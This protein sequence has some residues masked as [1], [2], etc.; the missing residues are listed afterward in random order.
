MFVRGLLLLNIQRT[1]SRTENRK[2]FNIAARTKVHPTDVQRRVLRALLSEIE[3]QPQD[4]QSIRRLVLATSSDQDRLSALLPRTE[5]QGRGPNRFQPETA[6]RT[7][8]FYALSALVQNLLEKSAYSYSYVD[9]NRS[10]HSS[11]RL[12]ALP[13][14]AIQTNTALEVQI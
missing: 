3:V 5:A 8:T 1:D 2:P 14:P 4:N 10:K 6:A 11:Q 9:S 13:Q 7:Q 12:C